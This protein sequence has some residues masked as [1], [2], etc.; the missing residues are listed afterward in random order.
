[1][2]LLGRRKSFDYKL[3]LDVSCE[4][5]IEEVERLAHD[6]DYLALAA[7]SLQYLRSSHLSP[8]YFI[9]RKW[10]GRMLEKAGSDAVDAILAV[11]RF[12]QTLD[13]LAIVLVQIADPKAV[14]TLKRLLDGG[15]FSHQP[16]I[17]RIASFVN[18]HPQASTNPEPVV[19][20]VCGKLFA[21]DDT[22]TLNAERRGKYRGEEWYC[23]GRCRR[24]ALA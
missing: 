12:D 14:P 3:P 18:A 24:I 23:S 20:A 19:C 21:L 7:I 2:P 22:Q 9:A 17:D 8:D 11:L 15:A 13:E 1:M 4:S 10:A 16:D 6:R 5:M